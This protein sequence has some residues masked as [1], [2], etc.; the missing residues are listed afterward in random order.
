MAEPH[1]YNSARHY[2]G[3][4]LIQSVT[5]IYRIEQVEEQ[6]RKALSG[7]PFEIQLLNDIQRS[8]QAE[9]QPHV[10]ATAQGTVRATLRHTVT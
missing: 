7:Q 3:N 1:V 5:D 10:S 9:P 6:Q 2:L 4:P 8:E